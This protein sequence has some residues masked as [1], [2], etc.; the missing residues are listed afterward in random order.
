MFSSKIYEFFRSI[1]RR[2][3]WKKLFL[4]NFAIFTGKSPAC[5][6]I[7][8]IL[9]QRW[10]PLNIA[11]FLRTYI[12]KNI[13]WRLF[14]IKTAT[15]LYSSFFKFRKFNNRLWTI[16]LLSIQSKFINLRFI[17]KILI[18]VTWKVQSR[19]FSN[20]MFLKIDSCERKSLFTF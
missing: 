20:L 10:F 1:H 2:C 17:S 4:K 15:E 5:N 16:R 11:K 19:R 18:H 9:K 7:K 6:F 3:L 14:L 13:Y 12:V 8:M